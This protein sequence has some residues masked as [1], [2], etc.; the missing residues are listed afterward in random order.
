[1]TSRSRD[2]Y[3]RALAAGVEARREGSEPKFRRALRNMKGA[4]PRLGCDDHDAVDEWLI[5][6]RDLFD[7]VPCP[8]CGGESRVFI[9]HS[10][11]D[12]HGALFEAGCASRECYP[13]GQDPFSAAQIW[14][15]RA[16]RVPAR[17]KPDPLPPGSTPCDRCGGDG[18]VWA[19]GLD[20]APDEWISPDNRFTCPSCEGSRCAEVDA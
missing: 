4:W 17:P 7:L 13:T 19:E 3:I 9:Q 10:Y 18:W 20:E 2:T 12:F 1:M 5:A 15:R 16:P 8:R 6:H 11:Y 14:N